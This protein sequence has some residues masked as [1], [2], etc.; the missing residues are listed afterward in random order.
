M[1]TYGEFLNHYFMSSFLGETM[2]PNKMNAVTLRRHQLHKQIG[3][4]M[5]KAINVL[6]RNVSRMDKYILSKGEQ[7]LGNI[8]EKAVQSYILKNKEISDVAKTMGIAPEK[9]QVFLDDA[10]SKGHEIE[11]PDTDSFI[12]DILSAIAPIAQAGIDKIAAKRASKG[13]PAGVFGT[14]ASGGTNAYNTIRGM[15]ADQIAALAAGGLA[16][17]PNALPGQPGAQ[18]GGLLDNIR[19]FGGE[20]IDRVGDAERKKQLQKMI[21]LFIIGAVVLFAVI[22]FA[23]KA[24][25][26]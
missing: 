7:P 3:G 8:V 18:G 2:Q 1:N 19:L 12:G 25:K 26:K 21:P 16:T 9:A 4:D 22:F 13:K 6:K 23:S 15:S 20:I 24:G 17:N 11:H 14:L 5:N 10:E